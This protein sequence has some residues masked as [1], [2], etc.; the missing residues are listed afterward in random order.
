MTQKSVEAIVRSLNEAGVRYLIVG[1]LAVVAHGYTRF[2]ADMDLVLALDDDNVGDAIRALAALGYRP[3]APVDFI[4]FAD[5]R[6][7]HAWIQDKGLAVFSVFSPSHPATE[8][9]MFVET[10]FDFD[11]AWQNCLRVEVAPGTEACF[12]GLDDLIDMKRSVGRP[13]DLDDVRHLE[14][15]RSGGAPS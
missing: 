13:Q 10:P 14:Q 7:R 2:T 11:H 3:R 6:K 15:R 5:P 12:V 4:D 8:I 1:G 9:D